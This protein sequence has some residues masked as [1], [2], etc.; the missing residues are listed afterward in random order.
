[1]LGKAAL[2]RCLSC[3]GGQ[4]QCYR[5]VDFKDMAGWVMCRLLEVDIVTVRRSNSCRTYLAGSQLLQH[6]LFVPWPN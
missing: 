3:S 1:M 6:W 2:G 4:W 5:E